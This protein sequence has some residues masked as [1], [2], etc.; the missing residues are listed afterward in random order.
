MAR[1]ATCIQEN[2]TIILNQRAKPARVSPRSKR[3]WNQ[4]IKD[5]RTAYNHARRT[6]QMQ[7]TP[8]EELREARNHYYRTIRRTKRACW[9]AF[10]VG[11]SSIGERHRPQDTARCWQALGFTKP[12]SATTIPTLHGPHEQVASSIA[13]KEAL[14][15]EVMFLPLQERAKERTSPGGLGTPRSMK[16]GLSRPY[17]TK[18]SR[19]PQGSIN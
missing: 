16:K 13:E 1:E 5:A 17:S 9:E 15:R 4:E 3:W 12:S 6:W 14:I 7:A 2:L 10:L 18:R 19:K 8:T 11:P